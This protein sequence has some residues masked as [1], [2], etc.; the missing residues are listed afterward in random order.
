M[1]VLSSLPP[2]QQSIAGG[3]FQTVTKL[4]VTLGYGIATALYNGSSNNLPRSGYYDGDP[5][6]PYATVFWY[7]TAC[8]ALGVFMVPWLRIKTQGHGSDANQRG[9]LSP[10]SP[11]T[12]VIKEKTAEQETV[13]KSENAIKEVTV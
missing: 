13:S 7:S 1:Y 8:C 12:I 3:L 9:R 4:C 10:A 2:H 5:S 11:D 6:W